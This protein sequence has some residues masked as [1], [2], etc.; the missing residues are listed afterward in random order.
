MKDAYWTIYRIGT[1][2]EVFDEVKNRPRRSLCRT[3]DTPEEAESYIEATLAAY[4]DEV[5][6]FERI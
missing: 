2:V 3:F 4:K 1:E 5:A 6:I